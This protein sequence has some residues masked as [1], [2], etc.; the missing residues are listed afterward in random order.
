MLDK[1][2]QFQSGN[3]IDDEAR[4]EFRRTFRTTKL[5]KDVYVFP[6]GM[7]ARIYSDK[8]KSF[9]SEHLVDFETNATR[10]MR[11]ERRAFAQMMKIASQIDFQCSPVCF[12]HAGGRGLL[13]ERTLGSDVPD[14]EVWD[15]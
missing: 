7:I 3:P 6:R 4:E 10:L 15:D 11:F 13:V 5:H 9:S 1:H 8:A 14:L 12:R 2:W